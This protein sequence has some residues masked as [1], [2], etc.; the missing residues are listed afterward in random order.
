MSAAFTCCSFPIIFSYLWK[1]P[2]VVSRDG[3]LLSVPV[4]YTVYIIN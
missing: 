4:D 2:A 3:N 1:S